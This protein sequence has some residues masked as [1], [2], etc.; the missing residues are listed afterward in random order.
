MV[1][2]VTLVTAIAVATSFFGLAALPFNPANATSLKPMG[3]PT[4][5]VGAVQTRRDHRDRDFEFKLVA[6]DESTMT[7]RHERGCTLTRPHE[8]TTQWTKGENCRTDFETDLE[9]EGQVWPL[10]VGNAWSYKYSGGDSRGN[11]WSGSMT[12]QVK[13]QERVEVPLGA[14]DTFHVM[15]DTTNIR[16]EWWMSPKLGVAVRFK[17]WN[18]ARGSTRGWELV[19]WDPGTAR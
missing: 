1:R 16:R 6:M 15:C 14:F 12:C 13:G 4:L 17:R 5:N 2:L 8:E 9:R 11:S 7:W 10:T 19:T 3:K 18:S